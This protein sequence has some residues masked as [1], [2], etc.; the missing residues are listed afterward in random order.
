M[1]TRKKGGDCNFTYH[2]CGSV[3]LYVLNISGAEDRITR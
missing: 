1:E 2:V 3:I